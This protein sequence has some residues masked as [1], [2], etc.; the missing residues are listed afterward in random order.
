M[1]HRQTAEQHADAAEWHAEAAGAVASGLDPEPAE[2]SAAATA[3]G[4]A[5]DAGDP[6]TDDPTEATGNARNATEQAN[7]TRRA[8][9]D[10]ARLGAAAHADAAEAHAT[11]AAIHVE[12]ADEAGE[13]EDQG[14]G[15]IH[16]A[17]AA[18]EQARIAVA[19][20]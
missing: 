10:D 18:E 20:C 11:A 3:P 9:P 12:A 6:D 4:A 17:N 5:E 19:G 2:D 1:T 7:A 13:P 15:P 16:R 8:N 14:G